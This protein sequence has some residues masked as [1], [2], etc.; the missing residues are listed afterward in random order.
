M[1]TGIC[2]R[3]IGISAYQSVRVSNRVSKNGVGDRWTVQMKGN[4]KDLRKQKPLFIYKAL[5]IGTVFLK[6]YTFLTSGSIRC[7]RGWS[8]LCLCPQM[9][10]Q[11]SGWVNAVKFEKYRNLLQSLLRVTLSAT[12][13]TSQCA[14]FVVVVRPFRPSNNINF[15]PQAEGKDDAREE[16]ECE[17]TSS[18][19]IVFLFSFFEFFQSKLL[20]RQ[21]QPFNAECSWRSSSSRSELINM[22]RQSH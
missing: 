19:K 18:S 1:D 13:S 8:D 4:S 12:P 10:T 7:S 2:P 21:C 11:S 9:K 22:L 5:L 16:F 14:H 15:P 20:E 6:N 17:T 3:F